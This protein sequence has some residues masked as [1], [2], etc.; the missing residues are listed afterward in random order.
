[1]GVDSPAILSIT[2]RLKEYHTEIEAEVLDLESSH[3]SNVKVLECVLR[4]IL[5]DYRLYHPETPTTPIDQ[6][7]RIARLNLAKLCRHLDLKH[8]L[9]PASPSVVRQEFFLGPTPLLDAVRS[10]RPWLLPQRTRLEEIL[11]K[12]D[13]N[14]VVYTSAFGFSKSISL[15][16]FTVVVESIASVQSSGL[17]RRIQDSFDPFSHLTAQ[18]RFSEGAFTEAGKVFYYPRVPLASSHLRPRSIGG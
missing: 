4:V 6:V 15:P 12:E 10:H 7:S 5:S 18:I 8:L 16:T 17:M 13:I 14:F 11:A 3:G 2:G 1:M 9:P